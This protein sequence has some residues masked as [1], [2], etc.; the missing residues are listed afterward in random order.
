MG[1]Q[2]GERLERRHQKTAGLC[3]G[4]CY[5]LFTTDLMFLAGDAC[6][7]NVDTADPS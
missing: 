4:L 5:S 6:S 7:P 2:L 1:G 3:L